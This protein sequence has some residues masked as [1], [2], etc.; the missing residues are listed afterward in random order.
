MGEHARALGLMKYSNENV[1]KELMSLY[2]S[3]L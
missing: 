3:L 2:C 1:A